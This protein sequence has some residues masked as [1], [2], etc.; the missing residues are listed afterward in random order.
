MIAVEDD[1]RIRPYGRR[2]RHSMGTSDP[3]DVSA[4]LD[5]TGNCRQHKSSFFSRRNRDIGIYERNGAG[6]LFRTAVNDRQFD[7]AAADDQTDTKTYCSLKA[8]E[9]LPA[10]FISPIILRTILDT[11]P[12]STPER[13]SSREFI[14]GI[15]KITINKKQAT[16]HCIEGI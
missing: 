13:S 16:I 8:I 10:S 14:H 5:S 6:K 1:Y 11:R 2:V 7:R 9:S 12:R 3:D 15:K 4:M